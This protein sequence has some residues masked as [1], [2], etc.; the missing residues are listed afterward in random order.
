MLAEDGENLSLFKPFNLVITY[1]LEVYA[2]EK[3]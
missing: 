3:T 2:N 1:F